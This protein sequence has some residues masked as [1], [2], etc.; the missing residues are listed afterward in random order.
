M[1]P[2]SRHTFK[3]FTQP[4]EE[5]LAPYFGAT[6]SRF[7]TRKLR[8][9][10]CDYLCSKCAS[11]SSVCVP[12]AFGGDHHCHMA[13]EVGCENTDRK[14]WANAGT[15]GGHVMNAFRISTSMMHVV[16]DHQI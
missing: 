5:D 8:Q 3:P 13:H 1:R 9:K 12:P 7:H 4:P 2:V 15:L 11:S 6:F 14:C 10:S 16:C